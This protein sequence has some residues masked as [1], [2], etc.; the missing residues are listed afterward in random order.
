MSAIF[1][2]VDSYS[3]YSAS[4]AP[5]QRGPEPLQRQRAPVPDFAAPWFPCEF[6]KLSGCEERFG[7]DEVEAWI[8]HMAGMHLQGNLP[9]FC[10]CWF[11]DGVVFQAVS[12]RPEDLEMAYRT[13]MRHIASHF[14]HGKTAAD[15]R[16]DFH[17]LDHVHSHGLI[18]ESV[19]QWATRQGELRMPRDMTF[20]DP[21]AIRPVVEEQGERRRHMRRVRERRV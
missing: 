1:D 11:C 8:Q 5:P 9:T 7:R 18:T 17:F 2:T 14:C 4:T 15:V 3:T 20:T 13:R 19:F 10:I 16:W 21:P 12:E 6:R